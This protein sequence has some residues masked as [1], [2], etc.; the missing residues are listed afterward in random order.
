MPKNE[1]VTKMKFGLK[2]SNGDCNEFRDALITGAITG[3]VAMLN[4]LPD[5]IPTIGDVWRAVR[6]GIIVTLTFYVSNKVFGK[7]KEEVVEQ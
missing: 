5:S 2:T 3:A 1:G 7:K 6:L 4:Q